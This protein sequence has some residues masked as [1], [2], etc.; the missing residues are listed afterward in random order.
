MQPKQQDSEP[1]MS[2]LCSIPLVPVGVVGRMLRRR[3]ALPSGDFMLH[4][5]L[6]EQ[7]RPWGTPAAPRPLKRLNERQT[8]GDK[9]A[10]GAERAGMTARVGEKGGGKRVGREGIQGGR[11]AVA[12]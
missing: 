9:A 6:R 7:S 5:L 3:H 4:S 8:E 2:P 1:G 10:T 11:Y 12:R